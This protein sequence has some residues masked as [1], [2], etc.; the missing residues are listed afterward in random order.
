MRPIVRG[1]RE[2]AARESSAI[3]IPVPTSRRENAWRQAPVALRVKR[4]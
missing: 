1:G 2:S 3:G 4:Y